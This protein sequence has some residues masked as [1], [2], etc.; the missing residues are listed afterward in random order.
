MEG[1]NG[2]AIYPN[3]ISNEFWDLVLREQDRLISRIHCKINTKNFFS[4]EII[5]KP[6]YKNT[7]KYLGLPINICSRI[8][9]FLEY[10]MITFKGTQGLFCLGSRKCIWNTY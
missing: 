5:I 9:K 8:Q 4:K 1:D 3:D 2:E 7:L 10:F 6:L